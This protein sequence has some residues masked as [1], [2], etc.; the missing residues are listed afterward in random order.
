[1]E[2]RKVGPQSLLQYRRLYHEEYVGD[3]H[4]LILGNNIL[5]PVAS[6]YRVLL[7][8]KVLHAGGCLSLLQVGPQLIGNELVK[9]VE[10]D[11]LL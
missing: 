9:L 5:R 6:E 4:L 1:M 3:G 10:C 7:R 11:D 2:E 8:E